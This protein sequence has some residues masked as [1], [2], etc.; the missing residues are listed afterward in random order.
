MVDFKDVLQS[1]TL[2]QLRKIVAKM[3]VANYIKIKGKDEKIGKDELITLMVSHYRM[4]KTKSGK[5]VIMRQQV[6]P[7]ATGNLGATRDKKELEDT[8][9]DL[10]AEGEISVEEGKKMYRQ[11]LKLLQEEGVIFKATRKNPQADKKAKAKKTKAKATTQ[12]TKD[13]SGELTNVEKSLGDIVEAI[14]QISRGSKKNAQ[15]TAELLNFETPSD[16]IDEF[17]SEYD[18]N[19]DYIEANMDKKGVKTHAKKF[20]ALLKKVKVATNTEAKQ[21]KFGI[22]KQVGGGLASTLTGAIPML[23]K[24]FRNK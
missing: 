4:G 3:N 12:A 2:A 5:E 14:Q 20:H 11:Q 1:H 15:E 23:V 18:K 24:M 13:M 7:K 22:S 8:I 9:G 21:N 19:I 10:I 16:V 6:L 17:M